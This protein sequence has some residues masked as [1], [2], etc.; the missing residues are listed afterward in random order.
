MHIEL[1]DDENSITY[2]LDRDEA[3]EFAQR[4]KQRNPEG[5]IERTQAIAEILG[6]IKDFK[7]E[8]PT[9]T[10]PRPQVLAGRLVRD[11]LLGF[12]I[13]A[14]AQVLLTGDYMPLAVMTALTILETTRWIYQ[15][16]TE[17]GIRQ[18]LQNMR[19]NIRNRQRP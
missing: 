6:D 10:Q 2:K 7:I 15:R 13:V 11:F 14:A 1:G 4:M 9:P 3:R 8:I 17:H 16:K 19:E 18:K 5:E 12:L